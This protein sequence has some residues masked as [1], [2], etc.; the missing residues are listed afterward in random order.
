MVSNGDDHILTQELMSRISN[1]LNFLF[2]T[3]VFQIAPAEFYALGASWTVV[4]PPIAA[5]HLLINMEYSH[6][7][8]TS[9]DDTN[10][11]SVGYES[12]G[13]GHVEVK[14]RHVLSST[15]TSLDIA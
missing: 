2:I 5:N 4:I 6:F 9:F 12:S 8:G 3:L 14:H 11:T 10:T 1:S 15:T 7:K 13:P